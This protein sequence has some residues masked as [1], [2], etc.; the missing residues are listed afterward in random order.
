M[1]YVHLYSLQRDPRYF[2]D[3][4][5]FYPDRWLPG[6]ADADPNFVHDTRAYAPF[7]F[8]PNN[9]VGRGLALQEMRMLAALLLRRFE[10]RFADGWDAREYEEGLKDWFVLQKPALRVV[11]T[12]RGA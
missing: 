2:S 7:S 8:G 12:P 1:T 11:L 9:C 4:N 3:P 5:V 6:A 10:M